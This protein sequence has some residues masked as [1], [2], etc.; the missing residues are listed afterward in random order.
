MRT[1]KSEPPQSPIDSRVAQVTV[2]ADLPYIS[3]GPEPEQAEMTPGDYAFLAV[4]ASGPEPLWYFW[5]RI[6]AAEE[7]RC[8]GALVAS[9]LLS[10]YA[11]D[12]QA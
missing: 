10:R 7:A 2:S 3:Y 11:P 6:P 5:W 9:K 1:S 12:S 4:E 8:E